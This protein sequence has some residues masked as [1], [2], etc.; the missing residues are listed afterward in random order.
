LGDYI[1]SQQLA[2]DKAALQMRINGAEP[3]VTIIQDAMNRA[4]TEINAKYPRLS[5]AAR[6]RALDTFG[7]ALKEALEA[8]N[9]YGTGAAGAS[10]KQPYT[11]QTPATMGKQGR[12]RHY[13]IQ[14]GSFE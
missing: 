8:R 14:T 2:I 13:N 10:G 3:G 7:N 5:Y 12:T 4:K 11:Y 6:A 1:A 9:T